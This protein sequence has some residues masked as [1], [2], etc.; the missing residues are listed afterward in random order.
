MYSNSFFYMVVLFVLTGI[1]MLLVRMK[2]YRNKKMDKEY[3]LTRFLGWVNL[4][5]GIL[6]FVM[7]WVY[8]QWFW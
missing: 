6:I 3:K 7:N 1:Y 4:S 5:A 2:G 8:R